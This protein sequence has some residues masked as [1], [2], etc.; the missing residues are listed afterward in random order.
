MANRQFDQY[1]LTIQKRFVTLFAYVAVPTGTAPVLQKWNYGAFNTGSTA[2]T[3]T[4][5]PTTGGSSSQFTKYAQGAE[6]IF[7]VAR[8]GTGLWTLT[9]QDPYRRV[10]HVGGDHSI[11][12]GT[13]NIIAV[14]ENPT[15]TSLTSS[16]QTVIGIALLSASATLADPTAGATSLVRIKIDLGDS[17]EP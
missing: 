14:V 15:I 12:G 7:S 6:G 1:S 9:L 11:A 5:A 4:A 16:T 13:A 17:T 8:T 10:L 2:N 3:Y